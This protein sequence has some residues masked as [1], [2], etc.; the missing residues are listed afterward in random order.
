MYYLLTPPLSRRTKVDKCGEN[1]VYGSRGKEERP[2]L[3]NIS[4]LYVQID[5]VQSLNLS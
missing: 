3:I 2:L 5:A 4:G 1:T